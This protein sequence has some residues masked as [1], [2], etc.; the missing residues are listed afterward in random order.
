MPFTFKISVR[1]ARM[2]SALTLVLA[3]GAACSAGDRWVTGPGAQPSQVLVVPDSINLFTSQSQQFSAFGLTAQGDSVPVKVNWTA[4]GGTITSSGLYTAD[5]TAGDFQVTASLVSA[6]GTSTVG[7]SSKVRIKRRTVVAVYVSPSSAAV[8]TGGTAQFKA[9][10]R[11]SA[12][13]SVSVNVAWTATGGTVS[14]GGLYTAGATAGA[15]NVIATCSCSIGT[16]ADTAAVTVSTIPV[17]SVTVAPAND[18]VT[19]GST[20]QLAA[21]V[22]DTTGKTVSGATVTWSSSAAAATVSTTGLVTGVAAGSAVITATSGGKSGTAAITVVAAPV[23]SHAGWYVSPSGTSGGDGS[24]AHPWDLQTALS[25]GNGHVAPG[26]TIWLRGG[27]YV[28]YFTSTLNG[29]ASAPIVVRGYPGERPVIDRAGNTSPDILQVEGSWTVF[30]GFEIMNSI[31][32]RTDTRKTGVYVS[33]GTNIKLVNLLIHDTGMGVMAEAVTNGLEITGCIVYNEGWQTST[34]SNGHAFYL[35]QNAGGS[36]LIRDNVMFNAFGFG[37]HG[38]SDPG[39][40]DLRNMTFEGNV[41]F[42]NGTLSTYESRNMQIGG[43][44]IADGD[45]LQDNMTYMS[46]GVTYGNV[47]IGYDTVQNGGITVENNYIVGGSDI[48]DVGYWQNA[49]WSGN[50]VIGA[51][52]V[53]ELHDPITA[54]ESW[55]TDHYFRDPTAK[56]WYYN[57]T[58]YT[59]S[60]FQTATGLAGT[61]QATSGMP[62]QT[63]VFVR[64]NAYEAGRANVIVY[65]WGNLGAAQAD[66]SGVLQVGDQYVVHSVQ[67]LFGPPVA[68]GTYGGGTISIPMTAITPPAPIGGSPVAPLVTGPAFDVFLVQRVGP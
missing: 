51:S 10:G 40:G 12:G 34:R 58:A 35:K 68:S 50:T 5:S 25:G 26:D 28:G 16:L 46:P 52:S 63:V 11:T 44:N 47:R 48:V 22:K 61:D 59:L 31:L 41:A 18:T 32:T 24:A 56:A 54:G 15:F 33:T 45:V 9:Y 13:D 30:W 36:K 23:A 37:V 62:T 67:D 49:A 39:T 17:G 6:S 19:A 38:Y 4:T 55:S 20:V 7:G 65:N 21:T 43:M 57:G 2:R 29:T 3:A 1:L 64:P 42:N 66:L 60:G 53:T 27:T 8:P 14:S